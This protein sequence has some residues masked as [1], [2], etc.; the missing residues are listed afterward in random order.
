MAK[1]LAIKSCGSGYPIKNN[2]IKTSFLAVFI[3]NKILNTFLQ[4]IIAHSNSLIFNN[5]SYIQ[6]SKC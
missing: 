2:K 6:T 3:E 4:E 5:L 1:K